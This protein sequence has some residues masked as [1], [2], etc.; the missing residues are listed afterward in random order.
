LS[1]NLNDPQFKANPYPVYKRLRSESPIT[2]VALT[3]KQSAWLITRY[4]DVFAALKDPRLAKDRLNAL[5]S[6]QKAKQPWMPA[7]FKPLTRN[8]LDV[9]PPDHTRLRALVQKAFTPRFIENS[10]DRIESLTR[11]LLDRL[12]NSRRMELIA[13][14][15]LIVPTT[16]IAEILGV[17]VSD[18][19]KFHR[20]SSAIVASSPSGWEMAKAIP[21]V[22]LFLRYIRQLVQSRRDRPASDLISALVEARE[23]GDKLNE[24]ELVA[25]IFLLLVAGHETTVNL[26]GNGTLALLENPSQLEILRDDPT[27][28]VTAVEELLRYDGPL[29]LATERFAREDITIAG[30]RIPRGAMVHGV[31]GSANRDERY[32]TDPDRLDISREPNK[33]LGFGQGIHFCLG[34][35][36]ARLEGQIAIA[37]LVRYL[38]RLRLAIPRSSLRWKRGAVI[39][40]LNELPVLW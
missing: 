20:W 13:S 26:I 25:M 4:D 5:T 37:N 22:F 17:P 35:P 40:G 16:I 7:M 29:A 21:Y 39:R 12:Q 33:H 28:I 3:R 10:R 8:M 36:L 38:P 23:A 30:I 6:G 19:H 15:A 11:E 31:L 18:R 24:D 2:E 27:T 14:Y 34:A 1:I 32:F 9:D